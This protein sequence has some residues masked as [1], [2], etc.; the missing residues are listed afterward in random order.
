MRM[1]VRSRGSLIAGLRF[2]KAPGLLAAVVASLFFLHALMGATGAMAHAG[3]RAGPAASF[4]GCQLAH[5]GDSTP[6]EKR[7]GHSGCCVLCDA[8]AASPDHTAASAAPAPAPHWPTSVDGPEYVVD[9]KPRGFATS[10]SSQ[11]PPAF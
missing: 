10:W 9:M 6:A 4:N 11:A 5:H 7:S 8:S 3:D 1:T 2:S